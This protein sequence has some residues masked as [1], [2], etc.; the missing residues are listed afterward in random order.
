VET[1]RTEVLHVL[2]R[3]K[4]N[5]FFKTKHQAALTDYS[6]SSQGRLPE[7][8]SHLDGLMKSMIQQGVLGIKEWMTWPFVEIQL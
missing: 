7:L 5:A 6:I 3:I 1:A 8:R 4:Y 2:T